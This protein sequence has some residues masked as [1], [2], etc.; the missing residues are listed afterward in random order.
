MDDS[1]AS[2]IPPEL[3]QRLREALTRWLASERELRA[4]VLDAVDGGGSVSEVAVITGLR[5]ET[6]EQWTGL[7]GDGTTTSRSVSRRDND[8]QVLNSDGEI[9]QLAERRSLRG[10]GWGAVETAQA[11][12]RRRRPGSEG[13]PSDAD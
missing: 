8:H 3:A 12:S 9:D 2:G 13:G 10:G 6:L 11:R 4:A 5:E 1:R 7:Q